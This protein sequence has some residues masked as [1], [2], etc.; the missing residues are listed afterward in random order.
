[1]EKIDHREREQ[2]EACRKLRT[3]GFNG[4]VLAGTGFGKTRVMVKS[5]I[6]KNKVEPGPVL[7]LVPFEHLKTRF[8]D[9][10]IKVLGEDEGTHFVEDDVYC[11][12]A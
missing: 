3:K 10:F 8:K 4:C 6:A 12:N 11:N 2:W 1:M 9:E 7:I 5:I